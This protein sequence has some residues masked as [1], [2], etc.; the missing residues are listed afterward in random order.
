M[1][2]SSTSKAPSAVRASSPLLLLAVISGALTSAAIAD[3][4]RHAVYFEALGKGG[5]W[6]LGYDYLLS[7]RFAAGATASFYFLDDQ[8]IA[9]LSPYLN[10]YPGSIGSGRWMIQAGPQ[11][12]HQSTL[13]PVPEWTGISSGKLGVQLGTGY[14]YRSRLLFRAY[15][16]MTAGSGGVAPWLGFSLGW[17]F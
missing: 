5:L 14:E 16:M 7:E 2:S 4:R 15:A 6:G 9:S 10:F 12:V 13:S 8:R 17:T 3:P 1:Q 11:F